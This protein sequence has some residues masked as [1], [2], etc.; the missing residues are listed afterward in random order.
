MPEI[1]ALDRCGRSENIRSKRILP[2]GPICEGSIPSLLS[3]GDKTRVNLARILLRESDILLLDEPTNHLDI[4]SREWIEEA[5]ADFEGTKLFISHDRYFLNKFATRIWSMNG[6]DIT[7]FHGGFDEFIE[8]SK[9]ISSLY[10][11]KSR[12][13]EQIEA[14]YSGWDE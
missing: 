9:Q 8:F 11:K 1:N 3:G 2:L 10:E 4:E 7:D 14:L 5:V 6:G 12:L 13:E